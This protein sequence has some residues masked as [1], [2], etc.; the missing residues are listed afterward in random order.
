MKK[1]FKVL[2]LFILF[3]SFLIIFLP[4]E[5]VFFY[6]LNAL[7]KKNILFKSY[8]FEDK[9][10]SFY[11]KDSNIYYK[12]IQA[13]KIQDFSLNTYIVYNKLI[14]NGIKV[15]DSLK[16]FVP[17]NIK[18]VNIKYSVLNPLFIDIDI[19]SK[20]FKVKGYI[21]ILQEKLVL[22]LNVSKMFK[23]QYPKLLRQIKYDNKT[24]EYKYEYKL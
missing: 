14:I 8:I 1:L 2:V 19:Y 17:S 11:L 24:K 10:Y 15:D 22:N 20:E 16:Q 6:A 5:K 9:P 12:N 13:L 21:D 23:K 18:N 4:K 7:S 3:F